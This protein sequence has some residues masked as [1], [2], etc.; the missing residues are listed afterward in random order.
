MRGSLLAVCLALAACGGAFK[1]A[2]N[3]GDQFAQ[4][5]MWD[6]AAVEY[7]GAL[8]LEPDNTDVQIKLRAAMQKQSGERLVRGKAL[9]AR[10]E[11]EAGLAV[12]QEAAKLDAQSTEAQRALD[13]ANQAALRKAEELLGTAEAAKAFDLTQL[14]LAGSPHDPRAKS[15]D[16]RVRDALAEQSYAQAEQFMEQGKR[17]NA[18]IAY[19]AAVTYRPGFKDAKAQ[20][21]DVKQLLQKELTFYVVLDRFAATSSGE[22]DLA[23]RMK[24]ELIAQAFDERLPLRIVTAPP[25]KDGRGVHVAGA[26]LS[27]RFGPQRVASRMDECQYIKGYDTVPNPEY[28][29]AERELGNAEQGMNRA[30]REIDSIQRDVDR[31]Q[32]EVDDQQKEQARHEAD[33]DRARADYDRCTSSSSSS[34]SSSTPCS[35]EKSRYESAQSSLSSQRNRVQSA[36]SSLSSVRERMR[37]ANESKIRERQSAEESRRR[38]REIPP[39]VKKEHYERENYGVEI[40][41]ID[42]SVTLRLHAEGLQ[43]KAALLADEQFPQVIQPISDDGWLARPATCPQSGKPIRLPNEEMLRGE[44]VKMTIATLRDKVQTMYDSYRT[45]FLADARRQ[46]AGGVPE[47]AVESYVRYLL[48]GIKNI[49]PKDGKQIG[50][51]L[52]KTRGFSRIDLLGGL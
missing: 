18:L 30:E 24:P 43:D 52:R 35:S 23:T 17:G 7:Q 29:N 36:Q 39:T 46:E 15:M 26:L 3:R 21:G 22:Q 45:K 33:S 19:A 40:R 31:A 1:D 49:D 32:H 5:G 10:G 41:T 4:A 38:L 28:A 50:E 13:D 11:I 8:K 44:L 2:V 42:A 48:T 16:D 34:T 27:Y 37:S 51:F 20:I 6:K 14:V 9:M 47:D 12:I 25:G